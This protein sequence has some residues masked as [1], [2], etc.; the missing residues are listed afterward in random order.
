MPHLVILYTGNLDTKTDMPTLCR[1]L[2]DAHADGEATNTAR[3]SSPPA[4]RACWP[5]RRRTTRSPTAAATMP[6]STSTC[7]WPGR[8]AAVHKA[9]ATALAG[10]DAR[11]PGARA[12]ARGRWA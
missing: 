3:K 4:A 8:S 2:A 12:G 6:S 1:K 5:T 10:A 7:A 9:V 11:A